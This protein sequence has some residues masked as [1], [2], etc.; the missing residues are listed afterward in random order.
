MSTTSTIILLTSLSVIHTPTV[1]QQSL[2]TALQ[3]VKQSKVLA[4]G[5]EVQY[6][7]LAIRDVAAAQ[8]KVLHGGGPLPLGA[9][10][11]ESQQAQL[12]VRHGHG[13]HILGRTSRF[14]LSHGDKLTRHISIK[15]GG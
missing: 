2:S 4:I 6:T 14:I 13:L 1:S 12:P 9:L 8:L 11:W 15:L 7:Y 10:W 3:I 5:I